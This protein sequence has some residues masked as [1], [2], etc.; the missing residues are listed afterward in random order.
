MAK[1]NISLEIVE[2][3]HLWSV[4]DMTSFLENVL[5]IFEMFQEDEGVIVTPEDEEHINNVKLV[6]YVYLLSY[7]AETY[8]GK[9]SR[10]KSQHKDLW[11]RLEKMAEEISPEKPAN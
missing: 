7:L 5:P 11:R 10:I 3:F 1:R 8:A 9:F 4:K 2:F 6:R